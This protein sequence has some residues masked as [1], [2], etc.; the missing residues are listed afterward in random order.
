MVRRLAG[1]LLVLLTVVAAAVMSSAAGRG[2]AGSAT[3]AKL[4]G[5]PTVGDCLLTDARRP[6]NTAP[7]TDPGIPGFG[8]CGTAGVGSAVGKVGEVVAVRMLTG[9]DRTAPGKTEGCRSSALAYA[10]LRASGDAFAVPGT[11]ADDPIRWRYSVDVRTTWVTQVPTRPGASAWAACIARPDAI[12]SGPGRLA[13]AFGGGTLPG[14]YGTCWQSDDLSAAAQVVDCNSAH[15]AEL[16]ALGRAVSDGPL[17]PD[18]VRQSC[19]AQ[20]AIVLRR[21]DPTAGGALLV[22]IH[23]DQLPP[24]RVTANP[25]C[26]VTA[27]DG[28]RIVGSLVG[29]GPMPVTFAD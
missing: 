3:V 8:P 25:A 26:Y 10:G 12:A 20:A 21:A 4:P 23:P 11:P 16:I 28:R 9:A 24:A 14:A 19:V 13:D 2:V 15:V 7:G 27:A 1:A 17:S 6:P 5:P 29:L 22:R 18:V